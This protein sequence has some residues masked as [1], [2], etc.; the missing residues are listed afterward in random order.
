M[1]TF[2]LLL[3]GLLLVIGLRSLPRTQIRKGF[4]VLP[5]WDD[6]LLWFGLFFS[7]LSFG[8]LLSYLLWHY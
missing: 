4:G 2:L 5:L 3:L 6:L 7:A 8:L 1:T